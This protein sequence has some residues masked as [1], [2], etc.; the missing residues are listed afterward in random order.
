MDSPVGTGGILGILVDISINI[1]IFCLYKKM[2]KLF[3]KRKTPTSVK[4]CAGESIAFAFRRIDRKKVPEGAPADARIGLRR[5]EKGRK[6]CS[7]SPRKHFTRGSAV[8]GF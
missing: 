1:G 3:T 4:R 8:A 5:H 2:R 7:T 6:K